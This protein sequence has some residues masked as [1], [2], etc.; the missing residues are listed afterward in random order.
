MKFTRARNY[1]AVRLEA[2]LHREIPASKALNLTVASLASGRIRLEAPVDENNVNV[3]G[4][5]FAGSIYS[6]SALAA[7]G[8]TYHLL[9]E[10]ALPADLVIAEG[11]IAYQK[12]VEG[13]IIAQAAI[14]AYEFDEF[15][16]TLIAEGKA[17]LKTEVVVSD[18]AGVR[19]LNRVKLVAIRKPS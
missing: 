5:G 11:C 15:S 7:W 9:Q 13:M 17:V 14:S 4:T 18:C 19:A 2:L 12:P 8:L 1:D 3:H 16:T 6:V 10:C